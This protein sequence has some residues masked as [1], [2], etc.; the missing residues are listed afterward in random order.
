VA[1]LIARCR[2]EH[3][4]LMMNAGTWGNVIRFMPPLVVTADEI[5]LALAALGES[6]AA[7][8]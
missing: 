5:D 6:L 7:T 4:V 3:R 8:G 1:A 2:D